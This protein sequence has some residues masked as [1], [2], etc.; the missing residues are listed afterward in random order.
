MGFPTLLHNVPS[1]ATIDGIWHIDGDSLAKLS[2]LLRIAVNHDKSCSE[3]SPGLKNAGQDKFKYPAEGEPLLI[4]N[5]KLEEDNL[6]S[7]Q[8]SARKG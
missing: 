1:A 2:S 6:L 8:S 4:G 5:P 7:C 3:E